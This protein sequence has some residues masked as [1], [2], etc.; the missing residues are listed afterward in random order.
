MPAGI[1]AWPQ[2]S[3][4]MQLGPVGDL[5]WGSAAA[6]GTRVS[7]QRGGQILGITILSAAKPWDWFV[8]CLPVPAWAL[9]GAAGA[10]QHSPAAPRS[11]SLCHRVVFPSS[12]LWEAPG[13]GGG[14][15][16]LLSVSDPTSRSRASQVLEA[17]L[18][19]IPGFHP[20][21]PG[22]T[23]SLGKELCSIFCSVWDSLGH[24]KRCPWAGEG[25]VKDA[26]VSRA[27]AGHWWGRLRGTA[28]SAQPRE[29]EGSLLPGEKVHGRWVRLFPK[30]HRGQ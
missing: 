24:G 2:L 7:G 11:W 10:S 3:P 8:W 25:L 19:S 27:G 29:S 18:L 12:R 6:L 21:G 23:P 14:T 22:P 30:A 20:H 15:L 26:E 1:S 4:I 16:R 5:A 17:H 9:R 28:G 13:R